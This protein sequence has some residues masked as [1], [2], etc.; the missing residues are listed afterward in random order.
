MSLFAASIKKLCAY[1]R[2][3]SAHE[4][5]RL[6]NG[7]GKEARKT[8][9][10]HTPVF[11]LRHG[12]ITFCVPTSTA[13]PQKTKCQPLLARFFCSPGD[14]TGMGM[15]RQRNLTRRFIFLPPTLYRKQP[16]NQSRGA[17][18]GTSPLAGLGSSFL[19]REDSRHQ[20]CSYV[21][22]PLYARHCP[23]GREKTA[24]N[25]YEKQRQLR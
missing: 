25:R 2:K 12:R 18:M 17:C 1:L 14:R 23:G 4:H 5:N 9:R 16:G 21:K 22:G 11:S 19:G 13:P 6:K 3:H 20:G 7:V 15:I 10:S 24:N 8:T